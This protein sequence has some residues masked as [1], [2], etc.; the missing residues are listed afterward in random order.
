MWHEQPLS[1]MDGD[2]DGAAR[3]RAERKVRVRVSE[4]FILIDGKVLGIE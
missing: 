3:E 2:G 1:S 4:S